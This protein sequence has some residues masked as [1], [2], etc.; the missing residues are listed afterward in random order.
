MQDQDF[1][2]D[3]LSLSP[4]LDF[5]R[6]EMVAT[7]APAITPE[8]LEPHRSRFNSALKDGPRSS[9]ASA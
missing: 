2:T 5:S 8:L 3:R 4:K 1:A 6:R 7:E 9:R